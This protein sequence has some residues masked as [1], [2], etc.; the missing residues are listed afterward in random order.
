M[1]MLSY[2]QEVKRKA[3][4]LSSLWVPVLYYF[5]DKGMMVAIVS[6][7]TLLVL[8]VDVGKRFVPAIHELFK[9]FF[10]KFLREEELEATSL[11][12]A[13][14]F[15]IAALFSVIVFPKII[16][17]AALSVLVIADTAAALI[18]KRYGK[19]PV[20]EKT[21]EG[22]AGFLVFAAIVTIIVGV[23]FSVNINYY[24]T[25]AFASVLAAAAELYS[26]NFGVDDNFSIP[27]SYGLVMW[28]F[29]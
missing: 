13:T 7:V 8:S 17:I 16:C 20:N 27:L 15:M 5:L 21:A 18:G 6:L 4:H 14:P 11:T 19:T 2:E 25:G 9:S 23:L 12:G 29:W 26:K 28:F 10:G 22:S 24:Y 3:I 1:V